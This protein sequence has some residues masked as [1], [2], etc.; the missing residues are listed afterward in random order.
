MHP[1]CRFPSL[2]S[3]SCP[4]HPPETSRLPS[5]ISQMNMTQQDTTRP[6]T[7]PETHVK[8]GK[9]TH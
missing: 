5:D 7:D 9:A 4:S 8:A 1:N 2:H 3:S 6:G